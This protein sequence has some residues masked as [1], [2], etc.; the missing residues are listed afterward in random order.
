M[1]KTTQKGDITNLIKLLDFFPSQNFEVVKYNM[2][3]GCCNC[4]WVLSPR[5]F[6]NLKVILKGFISQFVRKVRI[7][8]ISTFLA[9]QS[10]KKTLNIRTTFNL[11]FHFNHKKHGYHPPYTTPSGAN[12]WIQHRQVVVGKGVT[13]ILWKF[14]R[15]TKVAF[16]F[17]GLGDF[18]AKKDWVK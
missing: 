14:S 5:W 11:K 10:H 8:T 6:R 7:H 15:W 4:N 18:R 17:V 16:P 1:C 2:R 9:Q 13:G 3:D 12:L